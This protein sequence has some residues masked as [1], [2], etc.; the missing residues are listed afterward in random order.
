MSHWISTITLGCSVN[1]SV[2]AH[3]ASHHMANENVIPHGQTG[4]A[5]RFC[6]DLQY[7]LAAW[8][9]DSAPALTIAV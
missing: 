4:T 3:R 8:P 6:P 5:H 1:A 9:V 2:L 7:F